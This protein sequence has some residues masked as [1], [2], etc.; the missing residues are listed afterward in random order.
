MLVG[1]DALAGLA[2]ALALGRHGPVEAFL[3]DAPS[4]LGGDLLGD[5]ER[6][7]VGVV[8]HEG[9][10]TVEGAAGGHLGQ[11]VVEQHGAGTQRL[12]EALLLAADDAAHEVL[13]G[14]ELG[15][16]R[17]HHVDDRVDQ[18]SP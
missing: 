3:V 12:A 10:G 17:A 13:G 6:E 7:A 11:G 4:P 8:Q 5:L 18:G 2:G 1:L 16:G 14:H 9:G 15:V